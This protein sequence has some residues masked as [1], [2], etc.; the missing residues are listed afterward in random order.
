M[1][2]DSSLIPDQK[3]EY[4]SRAFV[5]TAEIASFVGRTHEI[6]KILSHI[7]DPTCRVLTLVGPGGIGKTRLA[8]EAAAGLTQQQHYAVYVVSL[9]PLTSA[10]KVVGALAEALNFRFETPEEP[11]EQLLNFLAGFEAVLL[12][13]NFEHLPQAVELVSEIARRA[14]GIQQIVTAREQ[15]K[16]DQE[17][18]LQ[19]DGLA[20]PGDQPSSAI[21]SYSAVKL[22]VEI[23]NRLYPGFVLQNEATYVARICA[24]LE[25]MPLAIELAASWI[26]TL[27]CHDIFTE[28]QR[29]L[30]VL[31]TFTLAVP[32]R[33]RSMR[34]VLNTSWEKLTQD[35]QVAFR[36]LSVF[37][38]G[39]TL[40]ALQSI[41]GATLRV[42]S[43]LVE[44]SWVRRDA[45]IGRYEVHELLRQYGE[46]QLRQFSDE[47][48]QV[49][50]AHCQYYMDFLE[51]VGDQLQGSNQKEVLRWIEADLENIHLALQWA[52]DQSHDPRFNKSL[53]SIWFFYDTGSRFHEC[54]QLFGKLVTAVRLSTD[55][56]DNNLFLGRILTIYGSMCDNLD[57]HNQAMLLLER[58]LTILRNVDARRDIAFCLYRMGAA[59][60]FWEGRIEEAQACFQASFDLYSELG[61]GS[62]I[63]TA[64]GWLGVT[65][66][67]QGDLAAAEEATL[68]AITLA[69]E[70]ETPWDRA[71]AAVFRGE[72]LKK[73]GEFSEA[74]RHFQEAYLLY[75][76]LDI[77]WGVIKSIREIAQ[78]SLLLSDFSE[79]RRCLLRAFSVATQLHLKGHNLYTL[80]DYGRLLALQGANLQAVAIFALLERQFANL[81]QERDTLHDQ[82]E[83]LEAKLT[84]AQFAKAV[85][86]GRSL[87]L[88]STIAAAIADLSQPSASA[89]P[90]PLTAREMEIVQLIAEGLSN[91]AIAE[92][93]VLTPGT[94]KWYVSKIF[95]KLGVN[96]RTQLL[97]QARHLNLLA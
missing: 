4:Q 23:A 14:P 87:L 73:R 46:D 62:G 69:R 13:D 33:H 96:S 7:T 60:R 47:T 11:K 61:N 78:L 6:A 39:F 19:V 86:A 55:E 81:N 34:A 53:Y 31:E 79:A 90:D 50:D 94:V 67:A 58:A 21:E 30:D 70:R 56:L 22:F 26:R 17:R 27:S 93:L 63:V 1:F 68:T 52:A 88:E 92:K 40:D 28:L 29:G 97:V 72:V 32:E 10:D 89:I 75:Q 51:Q 95:S 12:F 82:L 9:Q 65:F 38:G 76:E 42:L 57:R 54:E 16:L 84:P 43:V 45:R 80:I 44:R 74:R 35:E 41:T 66:M 48:V 20:Y 49:R 18:I 85:E 2:D 8:T 91:R 25:G 15:L 83:A 59:L 77:Q 64:L 3:D 5:Q 37:R 36:R 24:L 71:N